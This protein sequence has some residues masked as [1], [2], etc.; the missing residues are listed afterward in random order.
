MSFLISITLVVGA[1]YFIRKIYKKILMD[2]KT[3]YM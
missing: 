1:G 2:I 3:F